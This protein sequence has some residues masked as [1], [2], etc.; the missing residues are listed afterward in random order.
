MNMFPHK[1][2]QMQNNLS[3]NRKC[4]GRLL[5]KRKKGDRQKEKIN[6]QNGQEGGNT[7]DEFQEIPNTIAT[8][9]GF[10]DTAKVAVATAMHDLREGGVFEVEKDKSHRWLVY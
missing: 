1:I 3:L 6:E 8:K 7:G 2:W 9:E 4:D 5:W 10:Q